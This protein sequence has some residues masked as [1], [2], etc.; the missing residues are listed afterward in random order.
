MPIYE[1]DLSWLA[2]ILDGEGCIVLHYPPKSGYHHCR[3][4]FTN[5]DR[6]ILGEIER[7]LG[8]L[9]IFYTKVIV[10]KPSYK[11]CY[12]IEVQRQMEAIYLAKLLFPYLKSDSKKSKIME[13]ALYIEATKIRKDG[14]ASNRKKRKG[15]Q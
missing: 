2:G 4:G 13:L 6:G 1:K 11:L 14:K 5:T 3:V 7:I 10:S 8:Y 9:G 15:V 12:H